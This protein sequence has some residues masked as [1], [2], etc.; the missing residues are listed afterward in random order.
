MRKENFL[1]KV[2]VI[3]VMK[4]VYPINLIISVMRK[5]RVL[6]LE[7]RMTGTKNDKNL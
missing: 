1:N 3:L 5:L 4:T 2:Q 7:A 6:E